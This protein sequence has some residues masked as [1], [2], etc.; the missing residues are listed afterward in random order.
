MEKI[1][2]KWEKMIAWLANFIF[3]IVTSIAFFFGYFGSTK[4]LVGYPGVQEEIYD[5]ARYFHQVKPELAGA[6]INMEE[7]ANLMQL[8]LKFYSVFLLVI[9][10]IAVVASVTME[11]RSLSIALFVVAAVAVLAVTLAG[12]WFI[13]VAY[14]V[15]VLLLMVRGNKRKKSKKNN[16]K[17]LYAE[18]DEKLSEK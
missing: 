14:L 17:D 2:R 9:L 5:L 15:V 4:V 1:S 3:I 10:L 18:I 8:F 12:L 7:V 6:T 13:S 11:K 16:K